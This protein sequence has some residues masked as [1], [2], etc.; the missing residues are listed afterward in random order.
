MATPREQEPPAN[1]RR[2]FIKRLLA[3]V[4][5]AVLGIVPALAGL[6]VLLDPLRRKAAVD[7]AVQVA[8][9]DALPNDGVP[10]KFTV[11]ATRVDAW[12]TF[13][14]VPHWCG[15]LAPVERWEAASLQRRLP[16]R[17]MFVDYVAAQEVSVS[18]HNS[19]FSVDGH[20]ADRASP[21]SRGMDSLVVELRSGREIW[22]KFRNFQAGRAEKIPVA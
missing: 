12:N 13:T 1:G 16:A 5:G 4:I 18:C 8:T 3:S 10:R 7:D 9:L 21:S 19:A 6:T 2:G 22:V 15:V 14:Q 17:G 11:L 20:I